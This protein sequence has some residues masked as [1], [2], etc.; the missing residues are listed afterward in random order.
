MKV[1]EKSSWM[2]LLGIF[3]VGCEVLR[4]EP[5][6]ITSTYYPLA[7]GNFWEYQVD[8]TRYFGEEDFETTEFFYRDEIVDQYLNADNDLVYRVRRQYSEDRNRWDDE[9]S[10]TLTFS[11]S[12]IIRHDN[13]LQEIVLSYPVA[14]DTEWNGNA[15]NSRPSTYF[16]IE[17]MGD[18]L[19]ENN[20]FPETVTVR[21]SEEDDQIT[22]R[23]IRYEVYGK[24][25]GLIESY[26]EVFKYCSRNECLGEQIIQ[27][28][29]FT[30][31]K[32]ISYGKD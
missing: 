6:I 9:K 22:L 3:A 24:E 30:H 21:Q 5:P 27:E 2:L 23:D 26:Y 7:T 8:N 19:V 15:Y 32:L 10:Y 13:N 4:E 25:V 1:L 16:F 11:N 14:A 17:R 29:R 28:G 18:Y 12:R 31:L 20:Y